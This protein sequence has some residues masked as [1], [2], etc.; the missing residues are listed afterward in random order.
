MHSDDAG[1]AFSAAERRALGSVAVQF[2]LNGAAF[3]SIVPRLP[4]IR[5]RL[6]VGLDGLGLALSLALV[7]GTVGGW[8]S[9]SIIDRW[10]SRRALIVGAAVLIAGL[11]VVGVAT[12][13]IVFVVAFGVMA[14]ADGVVDV[15]MNLQGSALSSRRHAPVMNRL[16]GLWSL[17]T[18]IG[19]LVAAQAASSAISLEVHLLV[20]SALLAL[21]L[22]FVGRGLLDDR[23]RPPDRALPEVPAAGARPAPA[24]GR[25]PL[26][27]LSLAGAAAL[28]TEIVP[29]DWAA[30]RLSEDFGASPGLAGLGF[31]AFTSGM[32]VGRMGGDSVAVR[33][34]DDRTFRVAAALVGL[35]LAGA[36]FLPSRALVLA[37]FA[38][39]GLGNATIFP[40]LYDDAAKAG[41]RPG[42]G[43]AWLR[44]GSSLAA[45]VMPTL[46]GVLAATTLTVGAATA[47]VTMPCV[48]A[49]IV[50]ALRPR[51]APS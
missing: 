2:F 33:L 15:A 38:L 16:H 29:S 21:G 6:G 37:A 3:A 31:V 36:A 14:F 26:L 40:K 43:L 19:G 34:G 49:L 27:M 50:L 13:P 41:A 51:Q 1:R 22:V 44:T 9:P 5:V 47:I 4:E 11:P 25:L 39:A 18:V 42:V 10:G 28:T 35:G 12:S 17:G 20:V 7:V 30:F 8:R 32:T 46:V 24:A 23:P 45:L 48:L